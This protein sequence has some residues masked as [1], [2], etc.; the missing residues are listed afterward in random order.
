MPSTIMK[1]VYLDGAS[2]QLDKQIFIPLINL[3]SEWQCYP[4]TKPSEIIGRLQG[5]Q[6]VI[7][8]KS[9][10]SRETIEANPELRL[11]LVTATGTNNVDLAA[12]KEH[13]ITVCNCRGYGT[14]A[15]SQHTLMLMLALA[16]R[17]IDYNKAVAAG[18][19]QQSSN[20]CL[21]NYP[22]MELAGKTLGIIGYGELGQAVAKLA[23]AFGMKV[24]IGQ[25]PNR[26]LRDNTISLSELLP[27]VDVLTLHCPLTEDTKN[28][29]AEKEL[30]SM[31]KDALLVNAARGGI[32][33]EQDLANV[34]K[35]GHLG[36]AATDV[37]TVEPPKEGNPLLDPS[38]PRLI[39]TPHCAW[40]TKEAQQR[41]VEQVTEN[42]KAFLAGNPIRTV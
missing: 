24:L 7:C 42:A 20:F 19:W 12:A 31:K 37:L 6:V 22:I 23:E 8:N 36:G 21:M 33:N 15:V 4:Q 27:Q 9:P 32:I 26:P 2:L 18:E 28:L 11:I 38:I 34:L 30:S 29:L 10:I 35:S 1:A 16:T 13:N 41:I 14:E 25:I 5:A 3:F 17:L 39:V 40:A